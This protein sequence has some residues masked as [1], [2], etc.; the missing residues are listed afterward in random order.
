[1]STHPVTTLAQQLFGDATEAIPF[2]QRVYDL[3]AEGKSVVLQAPTGAGKTFAALAP[4]VLGKWGAGNGPAARKL[5]YSLPLRV[6]AGSL[7]TQY[8]KLLPEQIADSLIRF[9]T[10]YSGATKDRFLDGGDEYWMPDEDNVVPGT[11]HA[12]F[13]TIDQTL[14]GFAGVPLSVSYRQANVLY[15]SI[16]SGALIFDE[17]HLLEPD[18]SFQTALHLLDKSPWPV[19]IMTA[20]MSQ[21]LRRELCNIL[22]AEEVVVGEEDISHIR[23][24]RD[25]VKHIS[26]ADEPLDGEELADKL[27]ERTLVICNRVARAQEVF[28]TLDKTLEERGDDRKRM[29]LH[30]R[31]LPEDR[32]DKEE[33]IEAWFGENSEEQA[34]LVATQVVEAGL[35]I[36]ADEMHTEI[37]PIDSFLQRIGR[38]ARFA[39]EDEAQIHV[40]PLPSMEEA[41]DFLP[42][43]EGATRRTMDHLRDQPELRFDDLQ[44][45]IDEILTDHHQEII[46]AYHSKKATRAT[47]IQQTRETGDYPAVK[48]LVRHIDNVDVIL[49]DPTA[50][51]QGEAS[52]YAYPA[53]SVPQGT[54]RGFLSKEGSQ[55]FVIEE[56]TD[57]AG[58]Q[59]D[60][61][62]FTVQPVVEGMQWPS[63]RFVIQPAHAAYDKRLGLRLGE[64]GSRTFEPNEE[65]AEWMR[66]EYEEEEYK[67]HIRRLYEQREVRKASLDALRRL[68]ASDHHPHIDVRDPQRVIDLVIWAHDLAKLA[69]G[70]QWACGDLDPPL[71]H[72]GR[73]DG[74]RPSSHAAESARAAATPLAKLLQANGE[75]RDTCAQAIAAI[76]THHSPGTT[77]IREYEVNQ[78]RR[79]YLRRIT[80]ELHET[81]AGELAEVWDDVKWKGPEEESPVWPDRDASSESTLIRA[82]LVYML[83][84]SDQL[85]TSE[86]SKEHKI[87]GGTTMTGVSNIL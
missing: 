40:Y 61:K 85:A 78:S 59:P 36:S 22:D 9:T 69:D 42:Y 51:E 7:K 1:M 29:L 77:S 15:G 37:S 84:R 23:S 19:L 27:G 73:I 45:L 4:F 65:A 64:S 86:V 82:L 10:Q 26:A 44:G 79:E 75:S 13:T 5:I 32:A 21:T 3:I 55:A 50:M 12:V 31:F 30:S 35:D 71:A 81:L 18:K 67:E 56:F 47:F 87:D 8:E 34:V 11:R 25:T 6:L 33:K 46:Q 48:I 83:R 17:F 66:Y 24:Q 39:G 2:Q 76:R 16:L 14:S 28:D 68:S 74:R 52:P 20:T 53:V 62:Y 38:S 80:P 70:W 72:G 49:A 43:D 63:R 58:Q 54:F 57:E 60:D 41:R